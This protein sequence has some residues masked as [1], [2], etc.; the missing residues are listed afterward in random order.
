[1]QSRKTKIA[2]HLLGLLV[3]LSIFL[4]RTHAR[5]AKKPKMNDESLANMKA[6]APYVIGSDP[7][8]AI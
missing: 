4:L 7:N 3:F 1:M 8:T 2:S 5:P 6:S